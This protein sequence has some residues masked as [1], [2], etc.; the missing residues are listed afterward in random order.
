VQIVA[1]NGAASGGVLP[2][3][4]WAWILRIGWTFELNTA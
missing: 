4:G 1:V 3:V 2:A